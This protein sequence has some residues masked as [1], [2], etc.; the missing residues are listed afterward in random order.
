MVQPTV[1]VIDDDS[2]VVNSLVNL[3]KTID[4]N[5]V[6]FHSAGEF[7][8]AFNPAGPSCLVLDV[9]MPAMSGLELQSELEARGVNL[10]IIMITGHGDVRM[11]VEAMKN[12]AVDFLEK[13]FRMQELCDVIQR[14]MRLA[15]EN[16]RAS[17]QRES[18]DRQIGQLT[19]AERAVLELVVAGRTNKMMADE[20]G[21]S[22]RA[23]EDR[24]ARMMKKLGVT[25]RAELL[26]LVGTAD[27]SPASVG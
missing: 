22:V 16:W 12:G 17:R 9:R 7:L 8:E 20:L 1:Y 3:V 23:I 21:L 15:E 18:V 2:A 10:P 6:A 24:R 4:L 27:L 13:P 14:A 11:A 5:V 25:S 19:P 26:R